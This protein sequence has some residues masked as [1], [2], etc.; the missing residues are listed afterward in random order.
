MNL[1]VN[2]NYLMGSKSQNEGDEL[3]SSEVYNNL[4]VDY[5]QLTKQMFKNEPLS[6]LNDYI[7]DQEYE[8]L[9]NSNNY[10]PRYEKE[11]F[12]HYISCKKLFLLYKNKSS[13]ISRL[14]SQTQY[15]VDA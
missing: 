1:P 5:T 7:S 8:E 3:T 13:T 14:I 10:N 2:Q 12:N 9:D 4:A 6:P 15:Q 11:F